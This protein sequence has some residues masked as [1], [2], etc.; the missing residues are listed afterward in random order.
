MDTTLYETFAK[1]LCEI[2]SNPRMNKTNLFVKIF[3][4]FEYDAQNE[5]TG[6]FWKSVATSS[7]NTNT[8]AGLL[9][10]KLYT[11]SKWLYDSSKDQYLQQDMA[12][13]LFLELLLHLVERLRKKD[14]IGFLKNF[15]SLV[16]RSD[17]ATLLSVSMDD[18]EYFMLTT[19]DNKEK[20]KK[21]IRDING[22]FIKLKQ[23]RSGNY[24]LN[25]V[26]T[27]FCRGLINERL[28]I[29]VD[30][31]EFNDLF[32]REN[33]LL[34]DPKQEN[35]PSHIRLI[36]QEEL[37]ELM[38]KSKGP[39]YTG[40][41]D[42]EPQLSISEA[43]A[44]LHNTKYATT[45]PKTTVQP[46]SV[47]TV[48]YENRPECPHGSKCYRKNTKHL[49]EFSHT[50]HS[51]RWKRWKGGGGGKSKRHRSSSKRTNRTR[52]FTRRR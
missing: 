7:C 11:K 51:K 39:T 42:H 8:V 15:S 1:D 31:R 19:P 34:E 43:L 49:N 30:N 10:D 14:D 38:T 4:I 40:E 17:E 33:T 46:Q 44:S 27:T 18:I 2:L 50:S 25:H 37:E 35:M 6:E 48:K 26:C 45:G 5:F 24:S 22:A 41:K 47:I 32:E 16:G 29:K 21:V 13:L 12:S 36:T 52:R 23:P 3:E 20:I 28:G 9:T